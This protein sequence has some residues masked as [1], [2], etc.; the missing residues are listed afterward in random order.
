VRPSRATEVAPAATTSPRRGAPLV[1][2]SRSTEAPPPPA[3]SPRRGVPL[4]DLSASTDDLSLRKSGASSPRAELSEEERLVVRQRLLERKKGRDA[5]ASPTILAAQVAE[6]LEETTK[7]EE[8]AGTSTVVAEKKSPRGSSVAKVSPVVSV[9]EEN[10]GNRKS[11][12]DDRVAAGTPTVSRSV[13]CP[14]ERK[15]S[16]RSSEHDIADR[17]PSP[18]VS[19]HE[20]RNSPRISEAETAE[21]KPSPR[22]STLEKRNGPQSSDHEVSAG[23]DGKSV[24]AQV[25]ERKQEGDGRVDVPQSSSRASA[26]AKN[27]AHPSLG[28]GDGVFS[29]ELDVFGEGSRR[30]SADINA[31][32]RQSL[33]G[34]EACES[35][36]AES[37]DIFGDAVVVGA[38]KNSASSG[39]VAGSF[40][41]AAHGDSDKSGKKPKSPRVITCLRDALPEPPRDS[42]DRLQMLQ[43]V[44]VTKE[45]LATAKYAKDFAKDTETTF[46]ELASLLAEWMSLEG[47]D[48]TELQTQYSEVVLAWV[49]FTIS[50]DLPHLRRKCQITFELIEKAEEMMRGIVAG[51]YLSWGSRAMGLLEGLRNAKRRAIQT[52]SVIL[53]RLAGVL[54]DQLKETKRLKKSLR[55][56]EKILESRK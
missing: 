50:S 5:S 32:K 12:P 33:N 20:R 14:V 52:D 19:T 17:K 21:R 34:L 55:E 49:E 39:G 18:R 1:D 23:A 7:K 38:M 10:K 36:F 3:T 54:Q 46:Q 53:T 26:R 43:Y 37:T 15:S 30:A 4:L 41:A 27:V 47:P 13:S 44:K 40:A 22:I 28:E 2:P 16:P 11:L 8:S 48:L 24:Q 51:S 42:G 25:V 31:A 35:V 6:L 45:V 29:E 9:V 56:K